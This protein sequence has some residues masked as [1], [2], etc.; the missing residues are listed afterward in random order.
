MKIC[1]D[2]GHF[3]KYNPSPVDKR[4]YESEMNW[5]LHNYL[6]TALEAYGIEVVTTRSSKDKDLVLESRGKLA[7]GCDLFIS[8][9]SNACNT[10]SVDY[11]LACC[12]VS[13]RADKIGQALADTV[14]KVMGTTQ[15]G[16]ILKHK[17]TDGDWYGVLRGAASVAVPGVLLEHSFHTNKKAT[18]WLLVD[19][20]LKKLAEAE[21]QTIANHYGI[22]K[23]ATTAK[24]LYRVQV[25]A[26]SNKAN[27]EA[28]LKK[29]K[30]AGFDA[31][32]KSE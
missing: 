16:R 6:K 9:H 23:T 5:K 4:Y 1:I 17:G 2:A 30:A 27:A 12:T 18:A 28:M 19:N 20:N 31:V 22:K 21:A 29:L 15:R 11:P 7:K 10:E 8:V 24:K 26:Y 13:G 25:G 32:I 3:G 14:A